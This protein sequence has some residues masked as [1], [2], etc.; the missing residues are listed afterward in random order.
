ML[1]IVTLGKIHDNMGIP[2]VKCNVKKISI[3]FLFKLFKRQPYDWHIQMFPF[4]LITKYGTWKD[5]WP[6]DK[7]YFNK[8]LKIWVHEILWV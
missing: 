2:Q 4:K 7:L 6:V 8:R 3:W 5:I 1:F